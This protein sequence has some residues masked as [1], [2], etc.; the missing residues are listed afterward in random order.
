MKTIGYARV[1]TKDQAESGLSLEN[2]EQKIRMFADLHD[3]TVDSVRVDAGA[4]AKS[5]KR[6]EFS[7][8][9]KE[10][11]AGQISNIIVYK[12][13]RLTRS[14]ADFAYIIDFMKKHNVNIYFIKDQ[15]DL[16]SPTGR[17]VANIMI[18]VSQWE[19]EVI[20]E[21]TADAMQVLKRSGK[22]CGTAP[23]G[24]QNV[25]GLCIKNDY[26]SGILDFVAKSELSL[27]KTA[28]SLNENGFV[29]RAGGKFSKQSISQ[30]KKLT[31][32]QR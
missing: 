8:I 2:Q 31:S 29:N 26:E 32:M 19:R 7:Q 27:Q 22:A 21:R 16:T 11:E 15:F 28:D 10:I 6:P 30:M 9:I 18:S 14:V 13:D 4:S 17:L 3:L 1:S 5:L 25:N 20:S 12:L 24:F 23:Y